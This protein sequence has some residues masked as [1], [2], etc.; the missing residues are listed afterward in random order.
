[1]TDRSYKFSNVILTIG[2]KEITGFASDDMISIELKKPGPMTVMM[3]ALDSQG[4]LRYC[5]IDT[6]YS[7][8][9]FDPDYV[10]EFNK[11]QVCIV[12]EP[13]D[14]HNIP[15][16]ENN[17]EYFIVVDVLDWRNGKLVHA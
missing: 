15:H 7:V 5:R 9:N 16:F 11:N 14:Y 1:M 6:R 10:Y 8:T 17:E 13:E 12:S 3:N 4:K 2:G